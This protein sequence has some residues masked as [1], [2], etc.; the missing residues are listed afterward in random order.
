MFDSDDSY[1]AVFPSKAKAIQLLLPHLLYEKADEAAEARRDTI[2]WARYLRFPMVYAVARLLHRFLG[3][4]EP[5][6]YLSANQSDSLIG[7]LDKW[8]PILMAEAF[9]ALKTAVEAIIKKEEVGARTIVRN[10]DWLDAPVETFFKSIA[11]TL[12]AEA[13]AA[14]SAGINPDSFGLREAFPFRIRMTD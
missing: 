14:K 3:K 12:E 9:D 5:L 2:A 7:T 6:G 1:N 11:R 13:K 8:A 4:P 10:D